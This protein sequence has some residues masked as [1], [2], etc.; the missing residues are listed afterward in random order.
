MTLGMQGL[1][2]DTHVKTMKGNIDT[3]LTVTYLQV[4]L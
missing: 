4:S 3:F 2:Q 1:E